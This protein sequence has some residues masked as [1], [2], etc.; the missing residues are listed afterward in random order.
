MIMSYKIKTILYKTGR[1]YENEFCLWMDTLNLLHMQAITEHHQLSAF[2]EAPSS[3]NTLLTALG[4]KKQQFAQDR[5]RRPKVYLTRRLAAC[6]PERFESPGK[7][8]PVSISSHCKQPAL[9]HHHSCVHTLN[10]ISL[11]AWA[12]QPSRDPS[13]LS[14]RTG[15]NVTALVSVMMV[16]VGLPVRYYP[17]PSCN[18][19]SL[20]ET[21]PREKD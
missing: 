4:K 8:S 14:C 19:C 9:T 20:W 3:Q 12:L 18:T 16:S 2:L 13:C 17:G 7:I 15:G 5:W 6:Y 21:A 10:C 1:A 11:I